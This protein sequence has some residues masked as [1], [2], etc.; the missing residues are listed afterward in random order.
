MTR[1]GTLDDLPIDAPIRGIACRVLSTGKATVQEYRFEPAP[2][3][4][5]TSTLTSRSP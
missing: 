2:R 5:A 4:R 1:T 3:F